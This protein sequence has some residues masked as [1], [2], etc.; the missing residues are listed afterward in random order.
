[1]DIREEDDRFV[2]IADI[3]GV[4]RE[5]IDI[6]LEKDVLTVR[7]ERRMTETEE[8]GTL[9]RRERLHGTFLRRFTLPDTVDTGG[10][11]SAAL[12]DGV[13]RIEIPKQAKPQARRITVS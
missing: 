9:R 6:S 3:P 8:T 2:L 4:E 10:E 13:L 1:V 7:G 11:I 5:A 12:K